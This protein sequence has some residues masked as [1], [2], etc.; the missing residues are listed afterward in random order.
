M[1]SFARYLDVSPTTL[2]QV[3]NRK[4]DFSK[5][6][7]LKVSERLAFTP[8]ETDSA[9]QELSATFTTRLRDEAFTLLRDDTF[10]YLSDWYYFAIHSLASSGKTKADHAWIAR[11]LGLTRPQAQD[12][13]DRLERLGLI[14]IRKNRLHILA[15]ALRTTTDVPSAAA[16][17]LQNDH[18]K[19][20]QQS[21]E[22]DSVDIRD[23]TS[24]TFL[25]QTSRLPKAK[26]MI[27][28]FRRKLTKHLEGPT[29]GEEVYVLAVQLFPVSKGV[30]P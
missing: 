27:K 23:I 25:C 20:A 13:L 21:L 22:T 3:F 11:R 28:N 2:S 29:A 15:G 5:R 17:H 19:L 18:L 26:A 4:R 30:R 14:A 16:R 7:L 9:L 8:S 1:R 6:N 10:R 24:M 12:A